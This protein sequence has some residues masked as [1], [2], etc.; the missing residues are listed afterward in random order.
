MDGLYLRTFGLPVL[1][2][3]D[4]RAV[5]ELRRKDVA[6]LVYIYV[7]RERR[8]SRAQLATLL[9]GDTADERARHSLTQSLRRIQNATGALLLGRDSVSWAGPLASDLDAF[10]KEGGDDLPVYTAPFLNGFDVG[11]GAEDFN[12]WVDATRATLRGRALALLD[13][14]GAAAELAEDWDGALRLARRA[15]EVDPLHEAAHRRIMLVLARA[16]ERNRA[17]QH[18]DEYSRWLEEEI[19]AAPDPG[20]A[21]LAREI[22]LSVEPAGA[23]RQAGAQPQAQRQAERGPVIEETHGSQAAPRRRRT[24]WLGTGALLAAVL[25]GWLAWD[26]DSD[27]TAAPRPLTPRAVSSPLERNGLACTPGGAVARFVRESY[28]D[29]A[30]VRSGEPFT[31]T[32]TLRN[33]GA[34]GWDSRFYLRLEGGTGG[35]LSLT[36]TRVPIRRVVPPGDTY[37]VVIPMKAPAR[38]GVHRE[39][40]SLRDADGAL[41]P[42]S[43]SNTVWA[44]IRVRATPAPRCT[45]ADAVA[46]FV[47]E[48]VPDDTAV[49]AGSAFTK[50]WTLQNNGACAWHPDIALR[51]DTVPTPLSTRDTPLQV[52]EPVEPG[53]NHTFSVAMRAPSTPGVYEEHWRLSHSDGET[54]RVAA[55]K[56]VWVRIVVRPP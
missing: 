53:E 34:C 23:P 31:K 15:V 51:R 5:A 40:W 26:A 8:H 49:A 52:S 45:S 17:L 22:R 13:S 2:G 55:S 35:R 3:G 36:S 27:G 47:S 38:E 12:T 39:D 20:T 10:T 19:G 44:K 4:E 11:G 54:I 42:V 6:L 24:G 14:R 37:T 29:N 7:E 1:R 56:T 50:S 16:G 48:T 9:W 21:A 30:P 46:K 33:T 25:I 18:F 43:S 28:P 32:W 41:V